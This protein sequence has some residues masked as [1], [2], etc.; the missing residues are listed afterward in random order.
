ME[1]EMDQ[2]CNQGFSHSHGGLEPGMA[3]QSYP[4]LRQ[5]SQAL[6]TLQWQVPGCELGR[7]HCCG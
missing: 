1:G 7:G 3:L 5:G 6:V 4:K 2:G